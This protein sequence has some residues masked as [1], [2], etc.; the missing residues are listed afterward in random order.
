MNDNPK[1]AS[2]DIDRAGH[3]YL[4]TPGDDGLSFAADAAHEV[5]AMQWAYTVRNRLRWDGVSEHDHLHEQAQADLKSRLSI[6]DHERK[7]SETE[8]TRLK[9]ADRIEVGFRYSDEARRYLR[10]FPWEYWLWAATRSAGGRPLLVTR[11]LEIDQPKP[12]APWDGPVLIVESAPGKI[13]QAFGFD[14]EAGIIAASLERALEPLENPTLKQIEEAVREHQPGVIHLC[15]INAYDGCRMLWPKELD[16]EG[17]SDRFR[18]KT[19]D[20][21]IFAD[22]GGDPEIYQAAEIANALNAAKKSPA[23]VTF[24]IYNSAAELAALSVAEG[25]GLAIGIQDRINDALAELFFTTFLRTWQGPATTIATFDAA[26]DKL[27]NHRSRLRGSGMT[28]WSATSLIEQAPALEKSPKALKARVGE[29]DAPTIAEQIEVEPKPHETINYALLHNDQ[30]VF[31]SFKLRN[32]ADRDLSNIRV[33][34]TFYVGAQQFPFRGQ[35]HLPADDPIQDIADQIRLPLTWDFVSSLQESVRTGLSVQVDI[36]GAVVHLS[37]HPINLLPTNEW[38]DNKNDGVW[39][40]SFVFPRDPAINRLIG[41]AEQ[42]LRTILD[43]G[44]VGFI[45]YDDADPT[46]VYRQIR[47]VWCALAFNA[48]IAYA[49]PPPTYSKASQRLRTPSDILRER[50]G[51][52][53]DLSLLLV[54]CLEYIDIDPVIFL[55]K[56]HA[57]AG[58]WRSEAARQKFHDTK[59]VLLTREGR[60]IDTDVYY[61]RSSQQIAWVYEKD[62]YEQI[63]A[64]VR[65]DSLVPIEATGIAKRKGFH[66]AFKKGIERLKDADGFEAMLDIQ[67]ARTAGNVTPLPLVNSL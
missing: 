5:L 62:A 67:S 14:S 40:P 37:T 52:C 10:H 22:E 42:H 45:G 9:Q 55:L 49:P 48:D 28:L 12:T 56:G 13:K 61:S 35:F 36:D 26:L 53:I 39:L 16:A 21:M 30:N 20:G 43:N 23:L 38:R 34:V 32:L 33:E 46:V 6:V 19:L 29:A 65:A 25:A 1:G 59:K 24:D 15:G 18:D 17:S 44:D 27:R 57:M 2:V 60:V 66:Q 7:L 50:R 3:F 64:A 63:V 41:D 47:A 51:T 4:R 58:F 54:A 11:Y 8:F 31:Q